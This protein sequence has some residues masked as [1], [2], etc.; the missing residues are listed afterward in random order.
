MRNVLISVAT[1]PRAQTV[2]RE[3]TGRRFELLRGEAVVKETPVLLED[4]VRFV[5]VDEG[6]YQVR[7]SDIAADGSVLG[8]ALLLDI[9]VKSEGTGTE[10]Y[11]AAV[12][13]SYTLE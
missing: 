1:E 3:F 13:L 11:P 8:E 7:V 12:G 4:S 5:D 6:V 10:V 9:E 2:G